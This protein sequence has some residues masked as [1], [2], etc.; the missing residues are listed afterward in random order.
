MT[1]FTDSLNGTAGDL[2]SARSGWSRP[3]GADNAAIIT[4]GSGVALTTGATTGSS[5]WHVPTSQPSGNDQYA[6]ALIGTFLNAFPLGVRCDPSTATGGGYLARVNTSNIIEL[7]RRSASGVLLSLATYTVP[8]PSDLLTNKV[9][10]EVVGTT[11]NVYFMGAAVIGPITRTDFASGSVAMLSRGGTAS[12]TVYTVD[13][14]GSGDVGA[15]AIT[16]SAAGT[17]DF[18]GSAAATAKITG[19]A[20][21]TIG[22]AGTSTGTVRVQG[23]A[24]GAIA[25]AGAATAAVGLAGAAS[26]TITFT[27]AATGSVVAAGGISGA[28]DGTIG[29]T[30]TAAAVVAVRAAATGTIDFAG[31]TAGKVAIS[32]SAA[33]TIG[34]TGSA[35]GAVASAGGGTIS[36]TIDFSGA[37]AGKVAVKGAAAASFAITGTAAATVRVTGL[38]SNVIPF[39]G[40]SSGTVGAP[41][42]RAATVSR[43]SYGGSQVRPDNRNTLNRPAAVSRSY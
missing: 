22:F 34:F 42:V 14:W 21:G 18:T 13:D 31:S 38:A 26:T 33:G 5:T 25:F 1:T 6:E 12:T 10:L 32:A 20:A 30:G 23:S 29:F 15:A 2:L 28:L 19:T 11:L 36:S 40:A 4:G 17:I 16:G 9:R 7:F 8:T 35:S 43:P 39:T 41:P 24:T 27:G 3:V 37:A